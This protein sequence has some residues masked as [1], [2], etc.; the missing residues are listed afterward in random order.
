MSCYVRSG[1]NPQLTV[2]QTGY[3]EEYREAKAALHQYL[4]EIRT[5]D[6]G[7]AQALAHTFTKRSFTRY[8]ARQLIDA[9]VPL[10]DSLIEPPLLGGMMA[11][12]ADTVLD[13]AQ[14]IA[15]KA[16]KYFIE[17]LIEGNKREISK[18]IKAEKFTAQFRM[19]DGNLEEGTHEG[20]RK[21]S[22]G[23]GRLFC[24][25]PQYTVLTDGAGTFRS[26]TV[27][28][29]GDFFNNTFHT[30]QQGATLEIG[31]YMRY[32][33]GFDKGYRSG[34]GELFIYNE[35]I[36][37]FQL[38]YSGTWE[39]GV[40]HTGYY[41]T[42]DGKR[43]DIKKGKKQAYDPLKQPLLTAP[44]PP[45]P[46]RQTPTSRQPNA[47]PK[48]TPKP[49]LSR[50]PVPSPKPTPAVDLTRPPEETCPLITRAIENP[51]HPLTLDESL[52]LL[53]T[54]ISYGRERAQ[55]LQ[56]KQ[57]IIVIGNT[58]AGKS[59][60]VNY[61]AGCTMDMKPRKE[62]GMKGAGSVVVVRPSTQGGLLDEMMPIGHTKTSKT[63]MPQIE[64]GLE[65]KNTYCDCPGFLDNRG[66]EINIANAVNI[67]AA[68]IHAQNVRIVVLI[69]YH[70]LMADRGRGLNDMLTICTHLFGHQENLIKYKDS[71]LLGITGTPLDWSSDDVKEW[72]IE[73]TP[74]IMQTL[75]E[76]LFLYDPLDRPI[77]GGWNR[78]DCLSQLQQLPPMENPSKI[79]RTVLTDTDEKKLVTL[80]EQMTADITQSLERQ[81]YAQA[82]ERLSHLQNL[83]LIDHITVERLLSQTNSHIHRHFQKAIDAFK[84]HCHFEHFSNADSLLQQLQDAR[85]HFPEEI[86]LDDLT[87][88]YQESENRY[89]ERVAK[90]QRQA[91]ELQAARGQIEQLLRLL[92]EQR[93]TKLIELQTQ[94]AKFAELRQEMEAQR[95]ELIAAT[96][97][98]QQQLQQE[99]QERLAAKEQ[100]LAL[101]KTL[102]QQEAQTKLAKE[103]AQLESDYQQKIS[104]AK[105]AAQKELAEQQKLQ[106][107]KEKQMQQANQ[108]LRQKLKAIETQ[109]TDA[110]KKLGQLDDSGFGISTFKRA[111]GLSKP[112]SKEIAFGKAD[113]EKYF[114]PVDKEPP[115][116]PDIDNILQGPCPIWPDKKVKDTH[117]LT[118][119]PT[120]V[121]G[122]P[123][124]FDYLEELVKHPRGGGHATKYYNHPDLVK[125]VKQELS[126]KSPSIARWVLMSKDVLP[127][128]WKKTYPDQEK[129]VEELAAKSKSPYEIPRVLEA[130][131]SVLMHY[132]KSGV[133]LYKE[134][135]SGTQIYTR[136]LESFR[137]NENHAVIGGFGERGLQVSPIEGGMIRQSYGI[138]VLRKF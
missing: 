8:E 123:L 132:V 84:T 78:T 127:N 6:P 119:I 116:P 64:T 79:F 18:Q 9:G 115:L 32:E 98:N 46:S 90:E 114:G 50:A 4:V 66:S 60:F 94:D 120:S 87:A 56:D 29:R 91:E 69:N 57:A 83:T 102:N 45:Q 5:V 39:K 122:H 42:T 129:L 59:T 111:I 97:T 63:F 47:P 31:H 77:V 71:L 81:N 44:P 92:E 137:N 85:P 134:E 40:P 26:H 20:G 110:S 3:E 21:M 23:V 76:R 61:L 65:E 34:K 112:P 75:A 36:Q 52:E 93:R 108:E 131:A 130:T 121:N 99:L 126:G 96:Q 104:Q 35:E 28:Y 124:T 1:C 53:T 95:K 15:E 138:G 41:L 55:K 68:L 58:G 100:E 24:L 11:S 88:Y 38:S 7:R 48:S 101:A 25:C 30:L 86:D 70:S 37:E 16:V 117:L 136:C 10:H 19:P 67:K 43:I 2:T 22:Q 51:H 128:S 80:S 54:C 125:N 13:K 73:D 105:Q 72:L 133:K 17:F 89:Q 109:K 106:A 62:L 135:Y 74:A 82:A 49:Q 33:G 12:V 27:N 107:A 113:W 103:K 118:L 14:G